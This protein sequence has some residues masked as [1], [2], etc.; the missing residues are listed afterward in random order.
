M[1]LAELHGGVQGDLSVFDEHFL[2]VEQKIQGLF[3]GKSRARA[4]TKLYLRA[5]GAGNVLHQFC[6]RPLAVVLFYQKYYLVEVFYV[7]HGICFFSM[8]AQ[9]LSGT[10]LWA[11]VQHCS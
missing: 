10:N 4:G 9:T 6:R 3:F 2:A 7:A 11:K 1:P 8:P 5:P